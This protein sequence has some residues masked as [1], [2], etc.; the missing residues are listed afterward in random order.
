M[1]LDTTAGD[2]ST[3]RSD[4]PLGARVVPPAVHRPVRVLVDVASRRLG[5]HTSRW[6]GRRSSRAACHETAATGRRHHTQ[7]RSELST[8]DHFAT[9]TRYTPGSS[10]T[11]VSTLTPPRRSARTAIKPVIQPHP[12]ARLPGR[13]T[14]G[15]FAVPED[16]QCG[17]DIELV[18]QARF[19]RMTGAVSAVSR[20]FITGSG[21]VPAGC[22]ILAA[23][24]R[25]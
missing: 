13:F 21:G 20:L 23:H 15:V 19:M 6:T 4:A 16:G 25:S 12:C 22:A 8:P 24:A 7:A 10:E 1:E 3:R 2:P 14:A 9:V 17:V 5:R 11:A 18:R